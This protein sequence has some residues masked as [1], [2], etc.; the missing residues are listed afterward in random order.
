M[1]NPWFR[2]YHEFATDHIIQ[3]LSFEDQRHYVILLCMKC[4]GTLDRKLTKT[5]RERI[6]C[7]GLNLDPS[8]ASF[9]KKRLKKVELIDEKWSPKSWE[10]RQYISDHSGQRVRKHRKTNDSCN[11]NE[12]LLK[13]NKNVT[14]TPQNRTDTEQIKS[15]PKSRFTPPT[16]KEVSDYCRERGNQV[17]ANV[18]SLSFYESKG[19]DGR[20]K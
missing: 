17:D 1:K 3:D 4:D 14:V 7:R 20:Q 13:R 19:L 16:I 9:V 5:A 12:P 11:G 8:S 6:I 18:S 10:S 2:L 15:K